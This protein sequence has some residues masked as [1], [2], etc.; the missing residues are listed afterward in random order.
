VTTVVEPAQGQPV[1]T[2]IPVSASTGQ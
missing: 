2:T 1:P